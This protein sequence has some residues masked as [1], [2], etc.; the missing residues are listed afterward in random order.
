MIET[1]AQRYDRARMFFDAKDF[2]SSSK[3]L[4]ELVAEVPD[5]G[6]LRLLLARAYYHSAQFGR[7]E[8]ELREILA[9]Y[10][11]EDYAYLLLG[12]TLQ[13]QSRHKEAAAYLRMAGA[14]T[15]SDLG[16]DHAEGGRKIAA[17]AP[18]VLD[19]QHVL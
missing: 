4:A 17:I 2:V 1:L 14:M 12:R 16:S 6:A 5:D 13:R 8:A 3:M 19:E 11:V 15:G 18:V 7:A 10:P 9:R